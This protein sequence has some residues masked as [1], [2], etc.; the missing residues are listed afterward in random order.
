MTEQ[1]PILRATARTGT[2]WGLAI[3]I[4]GVLAIMAP[5][6]SG[7][8][9]SM[10]VAILLMVAGIARVIF[11]FKVQSFGKGVLVFLFGGFTILCGLVLLARPLIVL[12]SITL[13]LISY[14]LLDGVMEIAAAFRLKPEKGW[15][16][17]LVGGLATL[18]LALLIGSGWPL[19]GAWAI[20]VLVG[21]RLLFA[22]WS[23]IAYGPTEGYWDGTWKLNDIELVE[24]I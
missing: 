24:S 20:G 8:A 21:V 15:G 19:S 9:V 14:F 3:V 16:W 6:L 22:G 7:I 5:L 18:M 1:V 17:M 23:M 12:A 2:I 11:A 13:V 10:I 4:L